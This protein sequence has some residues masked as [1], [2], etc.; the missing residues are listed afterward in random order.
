MGVEARE[1]AQRQSYHGS[2]RCRPNTHLAT[3]SSVTSAPPSATLAL[4]S[5]TL[6]PHSV[7]PAP[8]SVIPAQAGTHAAF[9]ACLGSGLWLH[10]RGSGEQPGCQGVRQTLEIA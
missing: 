8:S 7:I 3:L 6:A 10:R 4:S 5:A 9:A 1:R 2:L